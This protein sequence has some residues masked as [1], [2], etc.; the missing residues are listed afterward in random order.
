VTLSVAL[1]L[2]DK[3]NPKRFAAAAPITDT[4]VVD[5]PPSQKVDPTAKSSKAPRKPVKKVV[6]IR[7][8]KR[9]KKSSDACASLE[10]HQSTNSSDDV[11]EYTGTFTSTFP[12]LYSRT[13][14]GQN[15]M[16]KFVALG[17]ECVEYLKAAKASEGKF[18][19][20]Y[21]ACLVCLSLL[22][23]LTFPFLLGE[24]QML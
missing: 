7:S 21:F 13:I 3:E 17:N 5:E 24:L 23:C 9:V 16:R 19:F 14:C 11:R 10:A 6:V 22:L 1:F 15:L 12:C 20:L 2:S 8:S 4:P 18:L